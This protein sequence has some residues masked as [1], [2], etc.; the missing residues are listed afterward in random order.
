MK[1]SILSPGW[2]SYKRTSKTC[3]RAREREPEMVGLGERG[4]MLQP[5]PL[6]HSGALL[7]PGG[8]V[9]GQ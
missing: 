4:A 9:E 1:T 6:P 2:M 5:M 7:D 8:T 3:L